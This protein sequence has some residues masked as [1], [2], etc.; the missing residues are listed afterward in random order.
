MDPLEPWQRVRHFLGLFNLTTFERDLIRVLLDRVD[1][2]TRSII[3]GQLRRFNPVSRL[4]MVGE[5]LSHGSTTFYWTR[6]GPSRTND[7]PARIPGLEQVEKA[8]FFRV[9]VRDSIDNDIRIDYWAV[10]GVFVTLEY[11]SARRV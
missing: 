3:S 7:F 2:T 5:R 4:L 6:L 11:Y 9:S 8:L 1:G 10:R